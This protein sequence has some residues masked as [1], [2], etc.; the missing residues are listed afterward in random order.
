MNKLDIDPTTVATVWHSMQSICREMRYVIDRTSQNFLISQLHDVSVGI[1]DAQGRTVAVPVGLPVQFLGTGFAVRDLV[2]KFGGNIHPGDVFLTNDPYHGGH[3]CHLPDWAFLR[4]IF[5]KGELLFFTL[6]RAHQQD[7][8]GA[9]PGG[10][11]PNGFDIHSEGIC[12]PP[13]KVVEKGVERTD[14]F[15]LIWNNV[16][17]PEGVRIDN[18]AMLAATRRADQRIAAL[19]DHYG[20]EKVLACVEQMTQRTEKA[21]REEIRKIPDGVYKGAAATDD[22]GTE[23]DVPV[24]V[25]CTVTVKDDEI[26]LDFSES[27]AQRKG[28]I[29]AIYAATYG[30]A[31]AATILTFD[32]ALAD[33]H[34][35]GTM[36]PIKVVAP[37]GLVVNCQY[38]ATVGASPV[39]VG[40]QVME[41]VL[42]ALAQARPERAVA[43][44]GKHRGD[45][46]SSTD[47]RTGERYVRT[48]FDYDGSAGAVWGYDGYQGVSC[49]T[50]LGAVNRGDVE[51]MEIRL[52]WR[53]EKY[54]LVPDFTGA[55][56]WRGGPGIQWIAVNEGS[57]GVIATGSSDGDEIQGFGALGGE[58]V[59]QCRTFI[60]RG[61]EEIR[62]KPHRLVQMKH[63]DVI[64]KRSSGGGGVGSP[65]ERD[66]E[67][68][69]EDVE[70]ELVSLQ[71]ARDVYGVV[72]DPQTLKVDHGKTSD[73]RAS[74]AAARQ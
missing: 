11:F 23:L 67:M 45:Y 44:W 52:P 18:Y 38:P 14:I 32:P 71:A 33:Y 31:I 15:D 17:F 20:K 41:A 28:F 70:N 63:G 30:N 46:V 27:D 21:V 72:I 16:R 58:P 55:G 50:A 2:A 74:A 25:R 69:R 43:A 60:Q 61:D 62:L 4:P 34:N 40:I 39:N 9:Y 5:H 24:W 53:M 59:P 8:G 29:N 10:Y 35:E 66:P 48:S 68:V 51:E 22:D 57:D 49:M 12:I 36:R 7:T 56:R 1:W 37:A 73:L 47:P 64:D 54:E 13:T 65:W 26:T 19:L 42:Q 3:C 6:A